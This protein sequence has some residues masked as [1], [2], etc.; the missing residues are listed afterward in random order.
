MVLNVWNEFDEQ[1]EVHSELGDPIENAREWAFNV[2]TLT[3]KAKETQQRVNTWLGG[4]SEYAEE[5]GVEENI[6]ILADGSIQLWGQVLK[7][8]WHTFWWVN[9]VA[10][11][12]LLAQPYK[13]EEIWFIIKALG[14][15]DFKLEF[16]HKLWWREVSSFLSDVANVELWW[17]YLSSSHHKNN[18]SYTWGVDVYPDGVCMGYGLCNTP[19]SSFSS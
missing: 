13:I 6:E 5:H 9:V 7:C 4:N 3:A 15:N 17:F 10:E 19:F 18:D 11:K 2:I 8:S 16:W 1:E 12:D 14:W